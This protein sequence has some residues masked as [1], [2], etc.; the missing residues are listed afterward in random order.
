MMDLMDQDFKVQES[1][2]N[3]PGAR[4]ATGIRPAII[5]VIRL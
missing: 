4:I 3:E 1:D 2:E 5:T